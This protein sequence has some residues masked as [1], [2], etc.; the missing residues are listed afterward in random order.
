MALLSDTHNRQVKVCNT[1]INLAAKLVIGFDQSKKFR[2][3]LQCS[4]L[5]KERWVGRTLFLRGDVIRSP[6][7]GDI[8]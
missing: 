1:R 2:A 7:F 5:P 4:Q 6:W 3:S 8:I